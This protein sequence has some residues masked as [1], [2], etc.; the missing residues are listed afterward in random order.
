MEVLCSA[1]EVDGKANDGDLPSAGATASG[2]RK[3]EDE[4]SRIVPKSSPSL[5]LDRRS[6]TVACEDLADLFASEEEPEDGLD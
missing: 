2:W 5:T 4:S 6:D 1:A 3:D